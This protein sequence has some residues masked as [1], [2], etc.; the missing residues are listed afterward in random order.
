MSP[1]NIHPEEVAPVSKKKKSKTLKVFLGIGVLVAIPV[2]G[3]TF[4][5]TIGINGGGANTVEFAQG[6]IATAACDATLNVRANSVY[7]TS[8][9]LSSITISGIDLAA[10][11]CNGKTLVVSVDDG[12]TEQAVITGVTQ[13][14]VTLPAGTGSAG[15]ETVADG[16]T[17]PATT[18]GFT[19][20][21]TVASG[22]G[23]L[24]ISIDTP[25][26]NSL[27]NSDTIDKFL[28]Q[29]S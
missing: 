29:S 7:A 20:S 18:S 10:P 26:T 13:I 11:G 16:T 19:S 9:K 22:V 2:I 3:T 8:F 23:S 14:S 27:I 17:S 28:I 12:G 4:A 25:A 6:S 1:L 15:S 24:V 5:A 21:L